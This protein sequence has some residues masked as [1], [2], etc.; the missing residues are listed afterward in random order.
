MVD[1][2]MVIGLLLL[3]P[4]PRIFIA[5][6]HELMYEAMAT[7]AERILTIEFDCRHRSAY[8]LR[9]ICKNQERFRFNIGE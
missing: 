7:N 2:C 9:E 8:A 3:P 4:A 5:S 1:P 6:A